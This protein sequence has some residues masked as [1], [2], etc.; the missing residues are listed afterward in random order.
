MTQLYRVLIS[1]RT[2]GDVP[3]ANLKADIAQ[4]FK[5]QGEQLERMLSGRALIVSRNA[6][7]ASAEKLLAR[8]QSLGL[9]GRIEA[10]VDTPPEPPLMPP[11]V[12]HQ[13]AGKEELFALK[14]P[15]ISGAEPTHAAAE[16]PVDTTP[17]NNDTVCPKCG[18]V[19][20]KRTL[21]RSCGLDMPRY[22]AA[23]QAA[24]EEARAERIASRESRQKPGRA[25][26]H[27][28]P[29]EY[30]AG[31]LGLGFSGRLGR[32]D[33]LSGSL[34]SNG[35]WL[36][37]AFLAISTGIPG[38]F[39]LGIFL[40]VV[41]ALR[42]IAL[43]LQDTGRTGWLTLVALVPLL[44]ALMAIL[45]L[46]IGGDDDDN[47]YGAPPASGGGLR[48]IAI[49]LLLFGTSWVS[50]RSITQNPE[51]ALHLFAAMSSAEAQADSNM[52]SA[53]EP[54]EAPAKISYS[55]GNRVD[56]YVIAGCS[57]CDQMLAWL[58]TNRLRATI[59]QVDRDQ[60]AAERLSSITGNR[61]RVALPV[62]EVNGK[63]LPGNPGLEE[64]HRHLHRE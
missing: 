41:Y 40:S 39:G 31:I 11:P 37:F 8:L 22:L 64:V 56:I 51:K 47:D 3:L 57:D 10:Q 18:E 6:S 61:G 52:L 53:D 59:Y 25:S 42:C 2:I 29:G 33:Y 12:Q 60:H 7:A 20:P 44:G 26:H 32:L 9:E 62:L 55:S 14:R 28:E 16:A 50:Y 21:C 17:A 4:A 24:E 34:L 13:A 38:L 27:H 23:Q 35:I 54:T 43:R 46:F 63:L 36:A 15:A 49:L 19:Q 58:K 30:Q 1:G 48:A 5:L 45:L